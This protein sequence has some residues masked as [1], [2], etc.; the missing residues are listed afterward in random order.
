MRKAVLLIVL[1]LISVVARPA[2]ADGLELLPSEPDWFMSMAANV[3]E[4]N[5]VVGSYSTDGIDL[6]PVLWAGGGGYTDILTT[7]GTPFAYLGGQAL[8]INDSGVISGSAYQGENWWD[9]AHA[10]LWNQSGLAFED[11]HPAGYEHSLAFDVNN[12]GATIG[13]VMDVDF[14]SWA[15][16][17][18]AD[19]TERLLT[20]LG[21]DPYSE[22]TALNNAGYGTGRSL[23]AGWNDRAV[24]WAP[25]GTPID[26]HALLPAGTTRS[27]AMD[28]NE[29]NVAA[30]FGVDASGEFFAWT[31]KVGDAT[32]TI[33]D[34][35]P[36]GDG[37]ISG[38]GGAFA[39]GKVGPLDWRTPTPDTVFGVIWHN[40]TRR[41]FNPL[42]GFGNTYFEGVNGQG[43]AVGY[44]VYEGGIGI[45][46][47]GGRAIIASPVPEPGTL[48]LFAAAFVFVLLVRRLRRA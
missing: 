41:V 18:D 45:F 2:H 3:N 29:D 5:T 22:S 32:V 8:G 15:Y 10:M 17:W 44:S 21:A 38:I 4:N 19:G 1:S 42:A 34:A 16:M 9:P 43:V 6:L 14:Y 20:P 46:G 47:D 28:I 33:L 39:A 27:A 26:V 13:R 31:W 48:A 11:L 25:D 23:D 24:V 40:G 30:G 12:S 35:G 36:L 37:V 7:Y